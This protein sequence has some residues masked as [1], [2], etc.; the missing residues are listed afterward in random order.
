MDE[1]D[2]FTVS[3]GVRCV[4][5]KVNSPVAHISLTIGAGTRDELATQHGVAHLVEHLMFKGTAKRSAYKVNSLLESVGGELNAFTTKEE[6]VLHATC[7][8]KYVAQS[9]DL[10][11]DMAFNSTFDL[12]DIDKERDVII[13]EIN[14]YKDSPS[15]LIFDDFEELLFKGSG[16]GR[17]ILGSKRDLK[18]IVRGDILNFTGTNY[19]TSKMVFA[20]S[21]SLSHAKFRAICSRV[22]GGIA[23]AD[24]IICKREEPAKVEKFAV[25]Q[26]RHA[27]QTHTLLGGYAYSAYDDRRLPLTLLLNILGGPSSMSRLNMVLRE[28][29]A[30]TY[31][32]EASYT[33]F[34]DAGIFTLYFSAEQSKAEKAE[35]LLCVEV[36]KFQQ[37][38]MKSAELNRW[39]RQFVGQLLLSCENVE[40]SMLAIAKSELLYGEFDTNEQIID[41]I[42]SVTPA[43]ILVVAQDVL[44]EKNI[45][46][47]TFN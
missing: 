28:K 12:T 23:S 13:D 4:H 34:I 38:A 11:A 14:S 9:V 31:S 32:A 18:K 24:G 47:L 2:I 25:E 6:T 17:N 35:R 15:E 37:N 7:L 40:Q 20:A 1:I 41:K 26:N 27:H 29:H 43:D 45:S 19:I 46:K 42:N 3:S 36:D 8:S 16:L 10:L 5:R 22:F 39:K 44:A 33:P 21:S 30:L